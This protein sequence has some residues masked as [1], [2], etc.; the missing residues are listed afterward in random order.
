V[1]IWTIF[2]T[3]SR[4]GMLALGAAVLAFFVRRLGRTGIILGAVAVMGLFAFGPSRLSQMSS[5]EESA[6]G[7]VWAWKAGMEMLAARPIFGVGKG[8]FV[9]HH[10]RTAHNSLVLSLAE[11]GFVGTTLWMGLFYFAFRDTR[12]AETSFVE[13]ERAAAGDGGKKRHVMWSN[14]AW[15]TAVQA[16]LITFVIGAFFLSRTY[17]PPLYVYL[18]LA[19]A[20]ANVEMRAAGRE[21]TGSTQRDWLIIG[22]LT[23]GGWLFIHLLIRLWS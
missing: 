2:I 10:K 20:A 7:R 9:E 13:R 12:R 21:L 5:Q 23:I 14:G 19:V 4:G 8:Q 18:G 15:S 3:N 6:Q 22:A 16:S 17:T 1:L 11:C